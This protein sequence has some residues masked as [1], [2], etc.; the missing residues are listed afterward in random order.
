MGT[1]TAFIAGCGGAGKTTATINFGFCLAEIGRRV[2]LVDGAAGLPDLDASLGVEATIRH[3][4]DD[5]AAGR[6]DLTAALVPLDRERRLWLLAAG[7][8]DAVDGLARVCQT[9]AAEFDHVLVDVPS[10][11]ERGFLSS[12]AAAT[13]HIAIAQHTPADRR[14]VEASLGRLRRFGVSQD[15]PLILFNRVTPQRAAA[16]GATTT[17]LLAAWGAEPDDVLGSIPE[18]ECALLAKNRGQALVERQRDSAAAIAYVAA[19]KRFVALAETA[20]A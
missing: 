3:R 6:C 20:P 18:D 4:L 17:D 1:I 14:G 11:N 7:A 8:A 2:L 12:A 9:A 15:R 16:P 10:G 19:V 13:R 5:V